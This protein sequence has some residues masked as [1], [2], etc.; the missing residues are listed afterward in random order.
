LG[1][2]E[3]AAITAAALLATKALEAVGGRV[4]EY[5]WAGMGRL[6]ALVRSKLGGDRRAEAVLA[7]VEQHP[8]D[9]DRIR[10]LG[11]LL[12]GFADVDPVFHR[13]LAALVTD[14]RADRT[15]GSR[16]SQVY[17]QAQVA[18]LLNV[19]QARD[20]YLQAES[21]PGPALATRVRWPLPGRPVTNLPARNPKFTGRED[22]LGWLHGNLRP[23]QPAVVQPIAPALHGLG[24]VGKTQL[25]L[26]YAHRHLRDYDVIWWLAAEQSATIPDQLMALARRLGMAEPTDQ[27]ETVQALW[28]ELR[29]RDR[30][31]LVYDN[32]E[33]PQDL[34]PWWPPASGGVLV[35]S[36]NP[37]W[38]GVGLPLAVGVLPRNQAIAFLTRRLASPDP[39]ALDQLADALGDLP[40]AL[41]QAASYLEETGTP[42]IEYLGLLGER[43]YELFSSGTP[44]DSEQ[45][46]ATIWSLSLGH[47]RTGAPGA[48]DL[49]TLCAFLG[50]E[51]LPRSL[52]TDHP[53]V[54][55]GPLAV[56]IGD[57][58]GFQQAL[59]MLRR[60]SLVTV[61][62]DRISV[63][64]LVQAVVR[65]ALDPD[66]MKA[67]AARA[68]SL[69]LAG[70][71]DNAYNADTWSLAAPL[72]PHA[73]AVTDH[74]VV[75]ETAPAAVVRLLNRVGDYLWGRGEYRQAQPLLERTCALAEARLGAHHLDTARSLNLHG[76]VLR[77]LGDLHQAR[78][79]HERA[80]AIY[81]AQP[82]PDDLEI[83]VSLT[84]LGRVLRTQLELDRAR[85][86]LE[87]ALTIYQDQLGPDHPNT[88][89]SLNNLAR[90]LHASGELEDALDLHQRALAIREAGLGPDHPATASS[91]TNLALVLT[92]QG[93][94]SAARAR[95]ERAL[96]IF[97]SQSG[98][99]H[100][101][102][103]ESLV[104][105]GVV[106]RKLGDL[107]GARALQLRAL[108]IYEARF[109]PDHPHTAWALTN[110]ATVLRVQGD[111]G[112]ARA[113][114]ER[115]LAIH[116][117]RFD[118][119]HPHTAWSLSNLGIV[120]HAQ[121]DLAGARSLHE[122]ALAIREA[123]LGP[124][125][126]RVAQ[127]LSNLAAVLAAQGDQ[128]GARTRH[129]RALTIYE[130]RLGLDH[131][132]TVRAQQALR[133]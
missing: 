48:Q 69:V 94:L 41:E 102:T 16:A 10:A 130:A 51:D 60:Y 33:Q 104:D 54:L 97:D 50:P 11:E 13:E 79:L 28:D 37:A 59:G 85:S 125:H 6:T 32:A 4:G 99:D 98:R 74:T 12:A 2:I 49:L 70:F 21:S 42:I 22:L 56:A 53:E 8:D 83:A 14:A 124:N 24:G 128:A 46:I 77:D 61:H 47:L 66:Q 76:Q 40:L 9:Q 129:Q 118:P 78:D 45:T 71:P 25:A 23:G 3:P 84:N 87:S 92:D 101:D 26:E 38:S 75:D 96:A 34:R 111:L 20:I 72:V 65:Q 90:T 108:A 119:D 36:R 126:P 95:H 1:P 106:L 73:L 127:S 107:K 88:A 86:V 57:R 91:L 105:L 19:G 133:K 115:A 39:E 131:P 110:L 103:A 120:L 113:L 112:R 81:E 100:P 89:W 27:V 117:E 5:A 116:E 132:D 18:Q 122:R 35:T 43:V 15:I 30:W 63:H 17:G 82:V 64:R 29:H 93:E 121:G 114:H 80:L 7:E 68:V 67:W 52:F 58:Y 123:R 62:H 55:A 44:T 109:G 31:L